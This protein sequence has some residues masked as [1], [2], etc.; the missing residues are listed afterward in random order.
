MQQDEILLPQKTDRIGIRLV[1]PCFMRKQPV[2]RGGKFSTCRMQQDEILLPRKT[3]EGMLMLRE[4]A[5]LTSGGR[6]PE[7]SQH[8]VSGSQDG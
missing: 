8:R 2:L 7:R 5:L 3:Q 1:E 6:M 4:L